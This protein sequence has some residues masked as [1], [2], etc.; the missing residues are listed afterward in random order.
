MPFPDYFLYTGNDGQVITQTKSFAFRYEVNTTLLSLSKY[1]DLNLGVGLNPY[2]ATIAYM[3]TVPIVYERLNRC[4]GATLNVTPRIVFKLS[5][6]FSVDV[7]IPL[8]VYTLYKKTDHIKNPNIPPAQ[9]VETEWVS[10]FFPDT[11][12][13]RVG[14][15]YLIKV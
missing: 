1:V 15:M 3:P 6:R 14:I 5:E 9:Q 8:N 4:E 13:L 10:R 12:T 7:N 2:R 11:Y